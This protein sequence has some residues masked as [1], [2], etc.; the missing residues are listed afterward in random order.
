VVNA[1]HAGTAALESVSD[2]ITLAPCSLVVAY[3]D[4]AMK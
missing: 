2:K 1:K 4:E 3:N